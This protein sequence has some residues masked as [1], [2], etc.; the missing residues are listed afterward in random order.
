MRVSVLTSLAAALA[1]TTSLAMAQSTD[2][3]EKLGKFQTTGTSADFKMIDQTG[4]KADQLRKNLEKVKLPAGFKIELYAIVPDARHMAVGPQGMVT[5]VGTRKQHVYA[6]TDRDKDRVADEVKEFA[7]SI[8]FTIPNGVCFSKDGFLYIVEQNRVLLFPAAEFFYES[9]DVAAF[10]VVEQGPADPHRRGI[11]QSHGAGV[12]HRPGQQALY[13]PRPAL[14]RAGPGEA[15][16][17]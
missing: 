8:K 9:P 4:A 12:P 7:P 2:N 10:K 14:Q 17:I 16:Q 5:F 15:R 11:L 1:L 3:L 13:H 6:V